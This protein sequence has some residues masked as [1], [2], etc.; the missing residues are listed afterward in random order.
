[1][2]KHRLGRA[3]RALVRA[4][5]DTIR[6]RRRKL[7]Q[8][9]LSGPKPE[10]VKYATASVG[11]ETRMTHGLYRGLYDPTYSGDKQTNRGLGTRNMTVK[12][13]WYVKPDRG[14]KV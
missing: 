12:R 10:P 4:Y 11:Y 9:N 6:A 14:H 8:D 13:P 5:W 2:A 1:M 3:E 7:I